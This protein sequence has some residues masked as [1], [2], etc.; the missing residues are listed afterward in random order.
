M[1]LKAISFFDVS[2]NNGC[3]DEIQMARTALLLAV[4]TEQKLTELFDVITCT[5]AATL[6]LSVISLT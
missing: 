4:L 2:H 1:Q 6:S 3:S 5:Y